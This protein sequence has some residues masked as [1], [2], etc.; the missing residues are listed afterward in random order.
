VD[1]RRRG[2]WAAVAR[3]VGRQDL[4]RIDISVQAAVHLGFGLGL[5]VLPPSLRTSPALDVLLHGSVA[6]IDLRVAWAA[7]F[8]VSG[9]FLAA[10]CREPDSWAVQ[11]VAWVLAIPLVAM[12]CVGLLLVLPSGQGNV[13]G[14]IPFAG[15]ALW[16]LTTAVRMWARST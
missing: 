11:H 5:L 14:V 2:A 8:L 7:G 16:H 6:G 15:L 3:W 1:E 4:T 10:A 13:L 9:A 12:W